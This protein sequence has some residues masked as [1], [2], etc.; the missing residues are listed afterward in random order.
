LQ[1]PSPTSKLKSIPTVNIE[2]EAVEEE[3][4]EMGMKD[5][6]AEVAATDAAMAECHLTEIAHILEMNARQK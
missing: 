1:R 5:E 4:E 3:A 6:E 2:D